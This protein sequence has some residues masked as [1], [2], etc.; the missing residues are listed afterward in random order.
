MRACRRIGKLPRHARIWPE[1][2]NDLCHTKEWLLAPFFKY[3]QGSPVLPNPVAFKVDA[4]R[5]L[6]ATVLWLVEVGIR[7][8]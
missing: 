3:R 4:G 8:Y 6:H 2:D 5:Q 1:T 7:M